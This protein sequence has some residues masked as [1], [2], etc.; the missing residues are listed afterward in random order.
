MKPRK[1]SPITRIITL[2]VFLVLIPIFSYTIFQITR[3][4]KT[5]KMI[6]EIYDHQ[7]NG[8]LFSI[9]QYSYDVAR[10]WTNSVQNVYADYAD[11]KNRLQSE[12]AGLIS[13]NSAIQGIVLIHSPDWKVDTF[14]PEKIKTE[15]FST[16][17]EKERFFQSERQELQLLIEQAAKGYRRI[18]P[19]A[20]STFNESN[21]GTLLLFVI[22][23]VDFSVGRSILGGLI[24]NTEYVGREL[25]SPKFDEIE[26]EDFMFALKNTRSGH[27]LYSTVP[28]ENWTEFE[29]QK[30]LWLFPELNLLLRLRGTTTSE[31]AHDRT[32]INIY[33]L[34]AINVIMLAGILLVLSAI[35][36]E[37][38]LSK[39]KSDFVSNVSHELRTPLA[40]IRMFAETLEMNRVPDEEKKQQYYRIISNETNR[41]TRMIN[42]ILD[43]SRIEAGRK[44]FQSRKTDLHGLV[45]DVLESYRFHLKQKGFVLHEEIAEDLPEIIVD[46]EAVSQAFIN[47]LENAVKYSPEI[48]EVTVRLF[49]RKANVVLQV[50]DRGIGIESSHHSKIFEKFYRVGDSLVHNTK[51]SGLGLTLVQYIMDY[52]QGEVG[53]Q[54][55]PNQGSSFSLIFPINNDKSE[56]V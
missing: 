47:L 54:S 48:K 21:T 9:N 44:T 34:I 41:L 10:G 55:A 45:T 11:N 16:V 33:S 5:E 4:N 12:I 49:K 42:N 3:L 30:S 1:K 39:M 20:L 23:I 27:L 40:L 36:R 28:D 25:L 7:L 22:K 51:G 18:L 32:I 6:R 43:F 46:P 8:I 56:T 38:Q 35:S 31:L 37:M 15:I 2:F 13:D 52:H 26:T 24:V 29:S 17:T 53:V 14:F 19:V 50:Q